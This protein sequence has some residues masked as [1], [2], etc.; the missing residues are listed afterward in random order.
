MT[1]RNL[2]FVWD[3]GL[4]ITD[5]WLLQIRHHRQVFPALHPPSLARL[6]YVLRCLA[7]LSNMVITI[8]LLYI[9]YN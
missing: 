8:T 3:Y 4:L 7:Y 2:Y 6:E 1:M 9:N 5:R